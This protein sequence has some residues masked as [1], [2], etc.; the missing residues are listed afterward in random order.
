MARCMTLPGQRC[1]DPDTTDRRQP[2]AS[3]LP[4][5]PAL[6]GGDDGAGPHQGRLI[7]QPGPQQL[8]RT[9]ADRNT[10]K[11]PRARRCP[12]EIAIDRHQPTTTPLR[13]LALSHPSITHPSHPQAARQR[14]PAHGPAAPAPCAAT[15]V[16]RHRNQTLGSTQHRCAGAVPWRRLHQSNPDDGPHQARGTRDTSPSRERAP[17]SRV[18]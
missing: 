17:T 12:S 13:A 5:S 3:Q 18:P 11:G 2:W 7:P 15:G 8:L 6:V 16:R 14:P 9:A 4:D 1:T 10:T